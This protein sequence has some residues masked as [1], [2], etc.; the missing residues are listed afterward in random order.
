MLIV[1]KCRLEVLKYYLKILRCN[2]KALHLHPKSSYFDFSV[3]MAHLE[4]FWLVTN[5]IQIG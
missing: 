3:A 2:N 1:L 4:I 5:A